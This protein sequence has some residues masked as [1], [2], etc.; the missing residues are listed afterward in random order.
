MTKAPEELD[1]VW[2]DE[3][4]EKFRALTPKHQVFLLEYIKTEFEG[5]EA[6][7]RAYN[8]ECTNEVAAASASRLLRNVNISYILGRIKDAATEDLFIVLKAYKT[9]ARD[10]VKPVKVLMVKDA[11]TGTETVETVIDVPD[12]QTRIKGAEAL[13]KLRGFNSP[14]KVQDDRFTALLEHMKQT[15]ES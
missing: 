13:A 11:E 1:D 6:Y 7:R 4:A 8:D 10:A 12:H 2:D 15:R 3:V 9:A 5:A 14:E